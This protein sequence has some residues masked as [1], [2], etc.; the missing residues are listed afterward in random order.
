M[1]VEWTLMTDTDCCENL[2]CKAVKKT[3]ANQRKKRRLAAQHRQTTS[4]KFKESTD[5]SSNENDHEESDIPTVSHEI[6]IESCHFEFKCTF[7]RTDVNLVQFKWL[8][9]D[10]KDNLHQITQYLKNQ[11]CASLQTKESFELTNNK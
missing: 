5:L 4:K 8:S 11:V 1:Q 6:P 10:S 9:G 2:I 7:N 3:W